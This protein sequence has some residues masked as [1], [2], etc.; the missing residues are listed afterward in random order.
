MSGDLIDELSSKDFGKKIDDLKTF[1]H[2]T[3]RPSKNL[4]YFGITLIPPGSHQQFLNIV[5]EANDEYKS[6]ELEELMKKIKKALKED[7]WMIHFGV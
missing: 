1:I 5:S 3:N 2:N 6:E 7:K 4:A